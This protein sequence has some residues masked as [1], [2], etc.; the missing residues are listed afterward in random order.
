MLLHAVTST[1]PRT[2]ASVV[3]PHNCNTGSSTKTPDARTFFDPFHIAPLMLLSSSPPVPLIV[4][5]SLHLCLHSRLSSGRSRGT[6][7]GPISPPGLHRSLR[8][9]PVRV[10]SVSAPPS[11][12]CPRRPSNSLCTTPLFL[13]F[14]PAQLSTS[15]MAFCA[16][17]LHILNTHYLPAQATVQRHPPTARALLLPGLLRCLREVDPEEDTRAI[18]IVPPNQPLVKSLHTPP[19]TFTVDAAECRHDLSR[20]QLTPYRQNLYVT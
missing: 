18:D 14:S 3:D 17:S 4:R 6:Q 20:L 2:V 7:G 5:D 10:P 9:L 11:S 12:P 19:S 13:C 16:V 1:L 15:R 8:T